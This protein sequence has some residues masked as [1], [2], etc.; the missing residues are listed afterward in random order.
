M[1]ARAYL[2][3][4]SDCHQENRSYMIEVYSKIVINS[5]QC[6]SIVNNL[7]C[8][9][10][11]Q[12]NFKITLSVLLEIYSSNEP[13]VCYV[14]ENYFKLLLSCLRVLELSNI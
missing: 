13:Y 9:L 14:P 12:A 7:F 8:G 11:K 6:R 2:F 5:S 3:L 4:S 10:V 1:I